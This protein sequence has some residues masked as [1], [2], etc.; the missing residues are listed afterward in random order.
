MNTPRHLRN[1][2]LIATAAAAALTALA[3]FIPAQGGLAAS[4]PSSSTRGSTTTT[5]KPTI[6]LVH[7][8]WA[9]GSSFT[10]EA[11]ALQLAGY[12]VLV[13]PNPLRGVASDA[14]VLENFLAQKTSG[15][16]VLVGHSYGGM[17]ITAAGLSDPDVKALVYVDAYAPASGESASYLTNVLPGSLLNVPD[18]STVFDFVK[19]YVDAPQPEWD[20][21]IRL[22]KFKPIFAGSLPTAATNLLAVGQSPVTLAALGAPFVGTPAWSSVPSWF[23][24]G[25]N[26][27]L[28][29]AAEQRAMAA[30]A[31]G[32]VTEISAPHLSMLDKPPA[33]HGCDHRR[34]E[35]RP[36][37]E[38]RRQFSSPRDGR[39]TSRL[40][41]GPSPSGSARNRPALPQSWSAGGGSALSQ[42]PQSR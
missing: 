11:A 27:A 6:V 39:A 23:V 3:I 2:K 17:V 8:A 19:P 14:T 35:V 12:K 16:V 25:K 26:D 5:T 38:R 9:D 4:Y 10:P 24:I 13:A 28:L 1:R 29:P 20:A 40:A 42:F 21:Y 41:R 37:D 33:G 15:P 31:G 36:L 30:R 34:G 22:D 32:K 7:G 18:A